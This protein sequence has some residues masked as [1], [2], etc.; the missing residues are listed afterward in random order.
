VAV[1]IKALQLAGQIFTFSAETK[2]GLTEKRMILYN[3]SV[4]VIE[5]DGKRTARRNRPAGAS[6]WPSENRW[7]KLIRV[8][9]KRVKKLQTHTRACAHTHA[10]SVVKSKQWCRPC[11]RFRTGHVHGESSMR[12]PHHGRATVKNAPTRERAAAARATAVRNARTVIPYAAAAA[13][14]IIIVRNSLR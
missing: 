10:I 3:N 5:I 14:T 6:H 8:Y 9:K 4:G 2:R 12:S 1:C 13:R 7:K 11:L